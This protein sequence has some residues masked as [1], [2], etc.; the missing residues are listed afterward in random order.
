MFFVGIA[1]SFLPY[2]LVLGLVFVFS[3]QAP[4]QTSCYTPNAGQNK[5]YI[6]RMETSLPAS[7]FCLP[8]NYFYSSYC[9]RECSEKRADTKKEKQ[10]FSL[11]VC[12]PVHAIIGGQWFVRDDFQNIGFSRLNFSGLSPPLYLVLFSL[13]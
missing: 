13:I 5:E 4:G 6:C 11:L 9:S 3:I 12:M 7:A 10:S 1:G 8:S 2:L